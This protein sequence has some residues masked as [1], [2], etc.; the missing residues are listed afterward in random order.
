MAQDETMPQPP[1]DD[2]MSG[3]QHEEFFDE[4]HP[5][6]SQFMLLMAGAMPWVISLLFH[7]GVFLI[8][9]FIVTIV[10]HTAESEELIVADANWSENPGGQMSTTPVNTQVSDQATQKT[11]TEYTPNESVNADA[12]ITDKPRDVFALGGSSG[13]S[14]AD[15]GLE[16]TGTGQGPESTFLGTKGGNA[17]N[18]VFVI[19]RSGSMV[20]TFDNLR[21]EMVR[22]IS[23]LSDTE[24]AFH[25]ILF[26]QGNPIEL[27]IDGR[28][29][30]QPASLPNQKAAAAFLQEVQPFGS[31]DPI[32]ALKRAF[33]VLREARRKGKLIYL[34]TDGRFTDNEAVFRLISQMNSDK[35]VLINTFLYG[36]R[37]PEAVEAM[38]RI[39]DENG[40][41]YTFVS[42]EEY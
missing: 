32:P 2:A 13:G 42:T 22:S 25:I 21:M 6:S 40:G 33:A 28:K 26:A 19:D 8:L 17:R 39:A 5:E 9:I 7:V 15:L 1:A 30:L 37:P 29:M 27:A 23:E 31:T 41:K 38:E 12:N 35:S 4:E 3:E 10:M 24:Q 36:Q 34:L 11:E 14:A 16:D 20:S 18:V